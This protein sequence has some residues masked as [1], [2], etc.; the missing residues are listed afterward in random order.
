MHFLEPPFQIKQSKLE[1]TP[2]AYL[3]VIE[4]QQQMGGCFFV[5]G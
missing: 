5:I 1:K 4:P 3:G 2:S